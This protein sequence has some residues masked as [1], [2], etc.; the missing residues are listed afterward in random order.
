MQSLINMKQ[1][2]GNPNK[3]RPT[4]RLQRTCNFFVYR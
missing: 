4:I 1:F 2:Y 3:C